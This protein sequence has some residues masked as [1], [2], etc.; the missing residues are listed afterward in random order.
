VYIKH[1][2]KLLSHTTANLPILSLTEPT[3]YGEVVLIQNFSSKGNLIQD[4]LCRYMPAH[5]HT[6]YSIIYTVNT[7]R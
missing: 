4:H 3:T 1:I 6:I 5:T 2:K 7:V